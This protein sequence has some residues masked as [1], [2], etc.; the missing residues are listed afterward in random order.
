MGVVIVNIDRVR[1]Q[2]PVSDRY[3]E[4]RPNLRIISDIAIGSDRDICFWT[5]HAA[6]SP[7][8]GAGP[9]LNAV[10]LVR[11]I[12][13][14]AFGEKTGGTMREA[15]FALFLFFKPCGFSLR[16][17]EYSYDEPVDTFSRSRSH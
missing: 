9:N 15:T 12:D 14:L 16:P 17:C 8:N 13:N 5:K 2:D 7:A 4:R 11:Q 6:L 1:N 3:S 10:S